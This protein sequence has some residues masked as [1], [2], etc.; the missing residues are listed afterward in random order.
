[1]SPSVTASVSPSPD[2]FVLPARFRYG[3]DMSSLTDAQKQ[4]ARQWIEEGTKLSDFQKRVES[5]FGLKLTY[6]ETRLLVDDLKV[7]PKDPEPAPAPPPAPVAAA[8][9]LSPD[10]TPAPAAGSLAVTVDT[11]T[12]PGMAVSGKVTFSDGKKALWYVDQYGRP[13][14]VPEEKGYRPSREDLQE[15][16]VALDRELTR[17]GM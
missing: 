13:G 4:V 12:Q 8:P 1:M 16:Q 11:V 3:T 9:L 15:F 17:M 6:M 7:M 14:L 2:F 5:E 10:A